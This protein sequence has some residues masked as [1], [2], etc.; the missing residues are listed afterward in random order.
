MGRTGSLFARLSAQSPRSTVSNLGGCAKWVRERQRWRLSRSKVRDLGTRPLAFR[1]SLNPIS[2]LKGL[3][4]RGCTKWVQVRQRWKLSRSKVRD[5]GT[6]SLAFCPSL[7]LFSALKGL[8]FWGVRKMG[9]ETTDVDAK[10]LY[11]LRFGGA[12]AHFLSDRLSG[13][14]AQQSL[15]KPV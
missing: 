8:R 14:R 4:F 3:R 1:P 10:P 15:L 11:S 2:A 6:R 5:L 9:A 13:F 12:F 7:H